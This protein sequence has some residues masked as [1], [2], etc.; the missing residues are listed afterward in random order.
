MFIINFDIYHNYLCQCFIYHKISVLFVYSSHNICAECK[1]TNFLPFD[2]IRARKTAI[3]TNYLT[4]NRLEHLPDGS[5]YH[6]SALASP[7]PSSGWVPPRL[8]ERG[9]GGEAVTVYN[10]LIQ[11]FLKLIGA[12]GSP[13]DWRRIGPSP[14][15]TVRGIPIHSVVPK[16]SV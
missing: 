16:I 3:I 8:S 12:D 14:C 5:I 15:S 13:C 2:Q 7:F 4:K 11:I 10:G 6:S 1:G 9:L